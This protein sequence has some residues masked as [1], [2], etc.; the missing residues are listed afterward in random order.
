M[1]RSS[2]KR[3]RDDNAVP[4]IEPRKRTVTWCK[5]RNGLNT[6]ADDLSQLCSK[7]IAVIVPDDCKEGRRF[8]VHAPEF[9]DT[10]SRHKSMQ[11]EGDADK[12]C[13]SLHAAV[14][15]MKRQTG[16]SVRNLKLALQVCRWLVCHDDR[17]P[18]DNE[19]GSLVDI[20]PLSVKVVRAG[21]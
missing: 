13:Q 14:D 17:P 15:A 9:T 11:E 2:L 19:D 12:L 4:H 10:H 6:K 18:V 7:W 20:K 8:T 1:P 3:D 16:C 21:D 5:R